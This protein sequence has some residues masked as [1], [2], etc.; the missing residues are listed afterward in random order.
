MSFELLD[1]LKLKN[2]LG[3]KK[4]NLFSNKKNLAIFFP[5]PDPAELIKFSTKPISFWVWLS[6]AFFFI[7]PNFY[8]TVT[9]LYIATIRF[10]YISFLKQ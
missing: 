9:V 6:S 5:N 1:R 10:D 4:K 7:K 2:Q 8:S 3:Q